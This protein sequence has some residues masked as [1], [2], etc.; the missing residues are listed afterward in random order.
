MRSRDST[1]ASDEI[2]SNTVQERAP[3]AI[4]AWRPQSSTTR[5]DSP[6]TSALRAARCCVPAT[7]ST[8]RSEWRGTILPGETGA[9]PR[10]WPCDADTESPRSTWCP[11][12]LADWQLLWV[13]SQDSSNGE[14]RSRHRCTPKRRDETF[15][16]QLPQQRAR[17]AKQ[18]ADGGSSVAAASATNRPTHSHRRSEERAPRRQQHQKSIAR[19]PIIPRATATHAMSTIAERMGCP[20][21][22]ARGLRRSRLVTARRHTSFIAHHTEYCIGPRGRRHVRGT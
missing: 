18:T 11:V 5:R 20:R 7:D 14:T 8:P 2:G 10:P 3:P 13:E 15:H 22:H 19:P 12:R 1:F 4:W 9:S 17:P 6:A 21:R 16:E